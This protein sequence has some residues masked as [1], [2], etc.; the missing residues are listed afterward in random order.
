MTM[1][2]LPCDLFEFDLFTESP[3]F[4]SFGLVMAEVATLEPPLGPAFMRIYLSVGRS[5]DC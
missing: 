4:A 5:T 3:C 2:E 1:L